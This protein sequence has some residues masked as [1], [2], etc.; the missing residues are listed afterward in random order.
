MSRF[1]PLTLD[2][3]SDLLSRF[4]FTRRID[5]AHL[6]HTWRPNHA[7]YRGVD[8]I[9]AMWRYHTKN[10]GWSDIAQHVSIAP[11][12][13]IWTGR[14][15]NMPPASASGYN[16]N[17]MS[18]PF[19]IETI[20]D[21]DVGKNRLEGA[22]LEAV[23]GVIARIE[24]R[25]RL[26]G[27]AL[28]FHRSMTDQKSCPGD[29][30]ELDEIKAEVEKA[31]A[32]L[33]S[34]VAS[35]QGGWADP[36]NLRVRQRPDEVIRLWQDSA[37]R[38][39]DAGD[40]EPDESVM[41][42]EQAL[43]YAGVS[44]P[45]R[46]APNAQARAA[47]GPE[48]TPEILAALR[49]YVINLNQGR[50]S[51]DGIFQT[52]K[53]DVDAIFEDHLAREAE[54]AKARGERVRLLF[55]AHGGLIS[56]ERGLWI[57]HQQVEWWKKNGIYPIHFAWE[58]G[59]FDALRQ[60]ISGARELAA[61]DLWDFTSDPAIEF[62]ARKLGGLKL[63][64]AMKRSAELA[65]DENGGA[66]YVAEKLLEFCEKHDNVDIHAAGHSAGAIFQSHFIPAA[67]DLGV[68][69]F[70]T[71]ALLAPAIRGDG[72]KARLL[73]RIGKG[74][75]SLTMF[76]MQRDWEESD[77]VAGIYRKSLLYLI[78]YAL[79]R[80]RKTPIFGLEVS[81]RADPQLADLFGLRGTPAK[82]AEVVW[83]VT[84]ATS[85]RNAGTSKTH[86]GFDNDRATMDGVA[87]RILGKEPAVTFPEEAVER[88]A[89]LAQQP[90]GMP[91]EPQWSALAS[92]QRPPSGFP[93]AGVRPP[94]RP[95]P[96]QDGGRRRALCIGIDRYPTAPLAGCVADARMWAQTLGTLEFETKLLLDQE[97][98]R[99]RILGDLGALINSSSAGDVVVFQF[100][101]HGT[102]VPDL[103]GDEVGGTNG[104]KDEAFVPFDFAQGAF[105]ID[106]DIA[107]VFSAMPEGVNVTCFIDCC[108]SGTITRVM[109]G[110]AQEENGEDRRA[111]FMF[112]TPEMEAA[113]AQFRQ[114]VGGTG[115]GARAAD[116]KPE[117][118]R[119]A[120]FSACRD[121][122][123]A[124][125]ANGHG[126]FT[127]RAT[128]FLA[129]SAAGVTHEQFQRR[130]AAAFGQG[131]RQHPELDCAPADR[132][133][134]LLAPL[135]HRA[136]GAEYVAESG[137]R[138][139]TDSQ[140]EALAQALRAAA[141]S[142]SPQ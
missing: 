127:L 25:F 10:K 42:E 6:H 63:W 52:E 49:P 139:S 35:A 3:F 119:Q 18:G 103:D 108:H 38:G 39:I 141:N 21:F 97:A 110:P 96:A 131:A 12:G 36:A 47:R 55:W 92:G 24:E 117:N 32:A 5:S 142:L 136:A 14:N 66:R 82:H 65:M 129:S 120:V 122:E 93:E 83:A 29:S 54:A 95:S 126:D 33:A 81:V 23:I 130:V 26:G 88:A 2:E 34:A 125:E 69:P 121:Y 133:R 137:E 9:E 50:F 128:R 62:A 22:Q 123:V 86:G 94:V 17:A 134:R 71:L 78:H 80:E 61:R 111:R 132:A 28:R 107:D 124:Y 138:A 51:S 40:G 37:T 53:A 60:I 7:Q 30:L 90:I 135:T 59:F 1:I 109:V 100:A 113:H 99:S 75:E 48:L 118:M 91:L 64:S 68:P 15:W 44:N 106:D 16:G 27:D 57:A 87:W 105:L 72:F 98:T 70:R 45:V 112:A 56:E 4:A 79:E 101:G 140:N 58:T 31:R 19:M 8:T 43:L 104:A 41:S 74:I 115:I 116:R 46:P 13:T 84:E 102:E 77:N 67:L 85:G 73:N 89:E 76:T 20:G 11:D 114:T